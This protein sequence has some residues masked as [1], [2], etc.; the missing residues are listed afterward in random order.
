MHRQRTYAGDKT[1][2]A[3]DEYALDNFRFHIESLR[4]RISH[5]QIKNFPT[6]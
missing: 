1:V 3:Q 5:V 4:R 6:L 2:F